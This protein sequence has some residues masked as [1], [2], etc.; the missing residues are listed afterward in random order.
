MSRKAPACTT[1]LALAC[2]CLMALATAR[3]AG[4]AR[5][6]PPIAPAGDVIWLGPDGGPLP[7]AGRA[8]AVEFL[9]RAAVLEMEEIPGSQNKPLKVLLELD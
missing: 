9:R 3:E 5:P 4:A 1:A 7:F 8:D 2:V 6:S